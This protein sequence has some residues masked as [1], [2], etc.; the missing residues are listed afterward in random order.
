MALLMSGIALVACGSDDRAKPGDKVENSAMTKPK[1][2]PA[3]LTASADKAYLVRQ[4][5]ADQGV[6]YDET[7]VPGKDQ[8]TFS[9]KN[10]D[11]AGADKLVLA[12]PKE[13]FAKIAI[14]G[15][16][17]PPGIYKKIP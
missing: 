11:R 10:L 8:I 3:I 9:F 4:V 5:A 2:E 14:I 1:Y 12:M 13:V 17:P 7:P 15:G 6:Q 16:S